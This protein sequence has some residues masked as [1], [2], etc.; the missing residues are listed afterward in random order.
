MEWTSKGEGNQNAQETQKTILTIKQIEERRREEAGM[1]MSTA[2]PW[3]QVR[4]AYGLNKKRPVV[5]A[6]LGFALYKIRNNLYM[7]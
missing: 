6:W 4:T 5:R 7:E 1:T 3:H 2:L